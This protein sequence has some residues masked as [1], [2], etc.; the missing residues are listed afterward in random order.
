MSRGLILFVLLLAGQATCD[1]S[2]TVPYD[3]ETMSFAVSVQQAEDAIRTWTNAPELQL[4]LVGVCSVHADWSS[5]WRYEFTALD[6]VQTFQVDCATAEVVWWE[7]GSLLSAYLL[8]CESSDPGAKLSSEQLTQA[9][10]VFAA[11][12]YS[13]FT[14]LNLQPVT[15]SWWVRRLANGVW[16]PGCGCRVGVDEYTGEVYSYTGNRQAP[17][18]I[19]TDP[20]IDQAAA[21]ATALGAFSD[22]QEMKSIFLLANGGLWVDRDDIG[23]Q[24]LAW[25]IEVVLSDVEGYTLSQYLQ[26]TQ[27]LDGFPQANVCYVKVDAHTGE[28][29]YRETGGYLG[30]K[31]ASIQTGPPLIRALGQPIRHRAIPYR[32]AALSVCGKRVVTSLPPVIIAGEPHLYVRHLQMLGRKVTWRNGTIVIDGPEPIELRSRSLIAKQGQRTIGLPKQVRTLF[33]RAYV[34][35]STVRLL[36][37]DVVS[38]DAL[39]GSVNVRKMPPHRPGHP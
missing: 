29:F 10:S 23:N 4:A 6:N 1:A 22:L 24:R 27:N 30:N 11:S 32:K 31:P 16:D 8:R 7:H 2:L 3:P 18:T 12:R 37:G 34:P 36:F 5:P 14:Q 26:E 21:E 20:A 38:W 13:G 25:V 28:V 19:S 17:V 35:I 9:A 33:G 15:W 39:S